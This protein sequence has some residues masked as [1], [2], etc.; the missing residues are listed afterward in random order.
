MNYNEMQPLKIKTS[1]CEMVQRKPKVYN[2]AK[3][4]NCKMVYRVQCHFYK[5]NKH[6]AWA[7]ASKKKKNTENKNKGNCM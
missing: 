3:K 6:L 4:S 5:M 7:Q 1:S 2:E